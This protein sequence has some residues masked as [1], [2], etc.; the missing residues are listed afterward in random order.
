MNEHAQTMLV[1]A[2]HDRH[3]AHLLGIVPCEVMN[4]A[5]GL[6]GITRSA[7]STTQ[8]TAAPSNVAPIQGEVSKPTETPVESGHASSHLPTAGSPAKGIREGGSW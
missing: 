5:E 2:A 7:V 8:G 4:E 3:Q 6:V 1:C